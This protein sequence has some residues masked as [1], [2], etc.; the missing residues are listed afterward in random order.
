MQKV[1]IGKTRGEMFKRVYITDREGLPGL[2][3][4][5]AQKTLNTKKIQLK[6]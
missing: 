5:N 6:N 4:R 3:S 2:I 1:L